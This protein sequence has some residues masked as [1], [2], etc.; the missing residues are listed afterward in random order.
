MTTS[1][2]PSV[3]FDVEK[4]RKEFPILHQKVN[5]HNL[6]YFDN[7]A[8]SQKPQQVINTLIDYYTGI[9]REYSSWHSYPGRES[10]KS[11]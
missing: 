2:A 7:A 1:H 10:H 9:Q 5:G 3:Q 11:L 4:I 6:V 8:T